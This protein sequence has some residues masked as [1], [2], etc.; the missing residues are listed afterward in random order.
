MN[1]KA[2]IEIIEIDRSTV[3]PAGDAMIDGVLVAGGPGWAVRDTTV[4]DNGIYEVTTSTWANDEPC[5]PGPDHSDQSQYFR[6]RDGSKKRENKTK[7]R[8]KA[9]AARK[10]RKANR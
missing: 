10:A 9:K 4:R 7:N 8:A 1:E 5:Q 3:V 2:H 6:F